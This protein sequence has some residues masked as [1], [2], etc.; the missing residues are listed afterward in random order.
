MAK[1]PA[2]DPTR[3]I[4]QAALK[5]AAREGWRR[6]TLAAI[7]A[8]AKLPLAT[9]YA[10]FGSKPAI[11]RAIIRRT[12]ERVL[13]GGAAAAAEP[14]HDRL[15][16]VLMRRF[17]A[18]SP[19][20]AGIAAI[21]RDACGGPAGALGLACTFCVSMA[22]ML[23]AA[24]V[25]SA[26]LAGALRAQGLALVYASAFRA[27][28]NDDSADMAKTMAALDRGLRRAERACALAGPFRPR[29]AGESGAAAAS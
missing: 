21:A 6:V 17:D 16:D 26:G 12:D 4:L 29:R 24:G 22:W 7:A 8:E 25:S 27:W 5:L 13:A 3:R 2:A 18:L 15:F 28:L 20:K 11:V 19:D 23:E 10:H 9:L 14:V 1:K